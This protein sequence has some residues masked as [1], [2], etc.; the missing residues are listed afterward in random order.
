MDLTLD[1]G[2]Y[3]W[4][5]RPCGSVS[6]DLDLC[7]G[8]MCQDDTVI[9]RY[10]PTISNWIAI[11]NGVNL[12]VQNGDDGGCPGPRE[13]DIHFICNMTQ[14]TP[15][16]VSVDEP[17]TC[18]YRAIIH[19]AAAC[20]RNSSWQPSYGEAFLS[21]VC[22]GGAYDLQSI[23]NADITAEIGGWNWT[24]NACGVVSNPVCASAQPASICQHGSSVYKLADITHDVPLYEINVNGL[25]MSLESGQPCGSA[26]RTTLVQFECD[27]SATTPVLVEAD[28]Y[29][30]CEYWFRVRTAAVCGEPFQ[31]RPVSSSSTV[32]RPSSSSSS[33]GLPQPSSSTGSVFS[34][35]SSSIIRSSSSSSGPVFDSSSVTTPPIFDVSSSS[36]A[37]ENLEDPG[38]NGANMASVSGVAAVIVSLM[39]AAMAL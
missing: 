6:S 18:H 11:P 13:S 4:A 29:Y 30:Q 26:N 19:T 35:S 15:R 17:S 25:N 32:P 7:D 2:T 12:E 10:E 24:I 22:G 9:S 23:S 33:T 20:N 34:S 5:I 39:A 38:V 1:D 3:V 36:T 21:T 37:E 31:I 27:P 28:E 14:L 16:L 8:Q